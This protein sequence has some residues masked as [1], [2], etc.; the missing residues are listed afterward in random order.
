MR[1]NERMRV[2]RA[3]WA[4]G[5][6]FHEYTRVSSFF[7]RLRVRFWGDALGWVGAF[8]LTRTEIDDRDRT[9]DHRPG[10]GTR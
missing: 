8:R 5:V 3:E 10:S 4:L 6:Y 1:G 9:P 7:V 2:E